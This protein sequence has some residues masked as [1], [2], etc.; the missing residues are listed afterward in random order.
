MT[1]WHLGPMA[2]ADVESTGVSVEDDRV[3]TACVALVRPGHET[4]VRSWLI[5]PQ[6][7]IPAEAT[8]VHGITTEMA[9]EKGQ[10]PA[11]ALD[12]IAGELALALRAGVPVV[13]M[14]V[15]FDLSMLHFDC[16]RHGV[17]TLSERMNGQVAPIVDVLVL[18]R[19]V[20][21]YR[22]G[23]RNLESL[24]G[25]YSV[26]IDGAHDSTFDALA[27]ARVAYRICQRYPEIAAMSLPDLHAAQ[28]RWYAEQSA[29]FAAYLMKLANQAEHEAKRADRE[30]RYDLPIDEF[31]ARVAERDTK[32]ADAEALRVKADGVST[33]WPLVPA[34]EAV[35]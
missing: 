15:A 10:Q 6:V 2:P 27:A 22:K 5:D 7:E 23:R 4:Q 11:E 28:V 26:R 21:R 18:D 8:A 16:L 12:L 3:V 31:E 1:G 32:L 20:D 35:A 29:G 19:K 9:R 14:N 25:H 17:P 30:T 13:G 33:A 24:C 34:R